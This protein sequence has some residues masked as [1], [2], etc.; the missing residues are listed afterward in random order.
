MA[1]WARACEIRGK[2]TIPSFVVG[3][4]AMLALAPAAAANIRYAVPHGN[5]A[6]PCLQS[7]PC[8][9]VRAITGTGTN[10]VQNSDQVVLEP[11]TYTPGQ[12]IEITK[13]IDV[14]GQ[15]GAAAAI[16]DETGNTDAWGILVGNAGAT[17]HDL[18]IINTAAPVLGAFATNGGLS[19]RISASGDVGFACIAS[20]VVL[21]RDSV[22]TNTNPSGTGLQTFTGTVTARNVTASGGASGFGIRLDASAGNQ[23]SLD[24]LNVIAVNG[25]H[26]DTDSS[27]AVSATMTLSHSNYATATHSG[28]GA[29]VTPA[30][31]SGNQ[32]AAPH[33]SGDFHELAGSPTI[34]AG[35]AA[36]GIGSLDLDRNP[37][38]APTC[39]GGPPGAPDI[40]AYEYTA[41]PPCPLAPAPPAPTPRKK[42]KKHHK[43]KHKHAKCGKKK[44]K[45]KR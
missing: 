14:G 28:T 42:C 25:V 9:S 16:L 44:R 34:D 26:A 37:R 32:T 20:G 18:R 1:S 35:L 4:V 45:K 43:H 11:G 23:D 29:T 17:V 8:N 2:A 40:G 27:S 19:E 12:I 7:D 30:G 31:A 24:A 15:A 39:L 10:G 36:P 41:P 21:L 13:A 3:V 33:L 5:G 6:Q 38:I 22:C